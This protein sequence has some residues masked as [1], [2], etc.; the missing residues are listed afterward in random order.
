MAYRVY[1]K[2]DYRPEIIWIRPESR[3][4]RIAFLTMLISCLLLSAATGYVFFGPEEAESNNTQAAVTP[5]TVSVTPGA[6]QEAANREQPASR[7]TGNIT[8]SLPRE[9]TQMHWEEATETAPDR[10]GWPDW[11][12]VEIKRGDN[13]AHIFNRHGLSPRDLHEILNS[14]ELAPALKRL[15]PGQVVSLQVEDGDLRALKFDLDLTRT[16]LAARQSGV[17]TSEIITTELEMR[18][19]QAQGVI[20]DSLYLAGQ[21]AGLSDRL[22]M[23][24]IDIYGWDIDYRLDIRKGDS[25]RIIYEE[26]FKNREK[27]ATGN[28]LA[29]EFN[30][31]GRSIRSVRFARADGQIDY[32]TDD[33]ANMRKA[34]IRNPLDFGRIS[35]HFNPKRKH[36]GLNRIRAHKGV[37]Y[38]AATGTPI[39]ATGDGKVQFIGNK[40]GYG[41]TIIVKHGEKYST[42]YAH[43]SRFRKGMKRGQPVKQGQVIGYVG[44]SGLATGPHLHYEFRMNGVHRNPVT[45]PLPQADSISVAETDEFRLH[46]SYLLAL[47][48][49]PDAALLALYDPKISL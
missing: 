46:S 3:R 2:N 33:G 21:D 47:L 32:F 8:A 13:M 1:I 17:F 31:Q 25:F 48:D 44:K 20:N 15:L 9:I 43:M 14:H 42:L 23:Q 7:F 4:G 37:D 29:A 18:V 41:K 35:S 11:T 16:L 45:V 19:K 12:N 49:N 39:K 22:I 26:I 27:V 6:V 30:N 24:L 34:F 28:I 40:G 38:A 10:P 36:P 5:F